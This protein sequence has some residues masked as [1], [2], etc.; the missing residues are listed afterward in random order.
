MRQRDWRFS[1][2]NICRYEV[3]LLSLPT[4]TTHSGLIFSNDGWRTE[5]KNLTGF[6]DHAEPPP[7]IGAAK[8]RAMRNGR[9]DKK[10][11]GHIH[12][13]KRGQR[14]TVLMPSGRMDK[15]NEFE[16]QNQFKPTHNCIHRL[17]LL[18]HL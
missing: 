2:A 10:T 4:E 1:S 6:A 17:I 15:F 5:R 12:S 14:K 7:D 9:Q 16:T 18:T 3:F 8:R 11:A 13:V